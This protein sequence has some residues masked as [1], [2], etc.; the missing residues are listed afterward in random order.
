MVFGMLF[1]N[2]RD[3]LLHGI[4]WLALLV[5]LPA[6]EESFTQLVTVLANHGQEFIVI[7]ATVV[8]EL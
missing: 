4:K 1:D 7:E 2:V 3:D 5:G 6:V 8:S